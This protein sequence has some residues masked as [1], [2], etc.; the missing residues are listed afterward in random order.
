MIIS[1]KKLWEIL[2][3][4]NMNKKDLKEESKVSTASIAKF[5]KDEKS[6]RMLS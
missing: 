4:K 5:G 1:Y 3:D 6:R 2:T